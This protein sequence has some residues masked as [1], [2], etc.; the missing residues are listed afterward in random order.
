MRTRQL[1]KDGPL[2]STLGFGAW[3]AGGSWIYGLGEV[4]DSQ[5]IATIRHA[6]DGGVNWIDTA[7]IYGA[8]RSEEVV[9][10]ALKGHDD[11]LVNTKCGHHLAPDGKATYVDNSRTAIRAECEAS[12]RRLGREHIDIYQFHLPDPDHPVEESWAAM[13]E[14]VDEGKVRWPGASNFD[15]AMLS[16]AQEVGQVQVTEPQYNVMHRQIELDLIPWCVENGTGVVAYELQQTGLLSGSFSRERL[17]ALPADDFRRG[18]TDF[19]EPLISQALDLVERL[20]PLAAEVGTGVGEIVIAYA[21]ARTGITGCIVGASS[22]DQVDGWIGAGD[23][24]LDG[25]LV[26]RITSIA[27]EAGFPTAGQAGYTS[28]DS[29]VA[30]S[31][32]RPDPPS[33]DPLSRPGC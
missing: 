27:T 14:L 6:V 9:G 1:G 23:L 31:P 3:K 30:G 8:G 4:D 15:V 22:P 28:V 32:S 5:S 11:V 25:E 21:L 10:R 24:V 7:P 33:H 17:A 12:L 2:V 20:R 29:R 19:Q 18:F 26:D 16:R 13:L